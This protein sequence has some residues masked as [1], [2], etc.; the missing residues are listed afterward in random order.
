MQTSPMRGPPRATLRRHPSPPGHP[1]WRSAAFKQASKK[2]SSGPKRCVRP[3]RLR[4]TEGESGWGGWRAVTSEELDPKNRP[5]RKATFTSS[6]RRGRQ[7]RGIQFIHG[8]G[9]RSRTPSVGRRAG[10]NQRAGSTRSAA[11]WSSL[12]GNVSVTCGW[13]PPSLSVL[14][15]A[16]WAPGH[17][18]TRTPRSPAAQVRRRLLLKV[19]S[20]LVGVGSAAGVAGGRAGPVSSLLLSFQALPP[21]SADLTLAL[22]GWKLCAALQAAIGTRTALPAAD[23]PKAAAETRGPLLPLSRTRWGEPGDSTP[24]GLSSPYTLPHPTQDRTKPACKQGSRC[25]H[26]RGGGARVLKCTRA[27]EPA[28]LP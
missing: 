11:A 5:K 3:P 14:E 8:R 22:A 15:L 26:K 17:P 6:P 27:P 25:D 1:R 16:G 23:R 10:G 12:A 24:T 21:G 28:R 9:E 20:P 2:P 19:R 13:D 7:G 18:Q 4:R